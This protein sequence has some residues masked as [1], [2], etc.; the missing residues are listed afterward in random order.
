MRHMRRTRS[1]SRRG[2]GYGSSVIERARPEGL[3][4]DEEEDLQDYDDLEDSNYEF[5]VQLKVWRRSRAN[6]WRTPSFG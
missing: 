1:R 6:I 3:S 5:D 2:D 4:E